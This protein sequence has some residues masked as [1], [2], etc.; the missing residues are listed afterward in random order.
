M[1]KSDIRDKFLNRLKSL[2][3]R[4]G[5]MLAAFLVAFA[6]DNLAE[7]RLDPAVTMTLGLILGEISKA[8]NSIIT[9]EIGK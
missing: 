2:A 1:R 8:L 3:W 4:M 5:M 6:L 7:F 9:D